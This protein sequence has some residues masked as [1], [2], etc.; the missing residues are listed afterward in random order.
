MTMT[1][2][3]VTAVPP[4]GHREAMTLAGTAYERFADVVDQLAE[5]D[6]ARRTDC[7]GWTVRD[8]V[9]HVVGAMR[10]A[11]SI[12]EFASQQRE[13]RGRVKREGGNETDHMTAVQKNRTAGLSTAELV[14]ECRRL[15]PKATTGRR[16][17]PAPLRRLVS[18]PV[19]I[20]SISERWRLGYLID[21]I[22]T[23]DAWL[24]RIDLCRAI[25]AEPMLTADHDG[26][27]LADVVAEWAR[28]HG[29][30]YHLV[31]TGPAGG[32]FSASDDGDDDG[33]S[34]ELDAVEFCRILSGRAAGAGLMTTEVPF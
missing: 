14:A 20:G 25:G 22:L 6:W 32:M 31:L 16:R 34:I 21:V 12:R 2:A 9:G 13:I 17:T 28:R 33:E 15:G 11:A 23:R 27:I 30:P 29:Q 26:R 19:E 8:L 5:P 1:E 7:E 3:P 18:F 24:H 10:S 4:L